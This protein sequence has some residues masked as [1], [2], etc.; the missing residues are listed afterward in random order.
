MENQAKPNPQPLFRDAMRRLAAT[1]TIISARNGDRRH[2]ITATAVT[3]LSMDP[4]SLLVCIN[5]SSSL[6]ALL[7]DADRFCV[8]LLT[9][10][11][12]LISDRF[13][14]RLS[15]DER[16]QHGEWG[17]NEMG[18]P[19]LCGGQA[20]V[21]CVKKQAIDYGS[22]TVFIGEVDEVRVAD[23]ISPLIYSNG[24][25]SRCTPLELSPQA[26]AAAA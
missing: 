14:G 12:A 4:A 16:F 5:Q 3:S 22:H 17:D 1:V 13:S 2:G 6:H 21:F 9:S 11:Q 25:Y 19:Y 26:A 8:N 7:T 23:E 15:A 20:N 18:V 10:E 24:V